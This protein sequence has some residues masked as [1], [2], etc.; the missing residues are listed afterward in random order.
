MAFKEQKPESNVVIGKSIKLSA[1]IRNRLQNTSK[2]QRI[3]ALV[4]GLLLLVFALV[5]LYL[6][7]ASRGQQTPTNEDV[8]SIIPNANGEHAKLLLISEALDKGD[9]KTAETEINNLETGSPSQNG[10]ILF[11]K[12]RL[13]LQTQQYEKAIQYVN[14]IDSE[15]L[16]E[17]LAIPVSQENIDTIRSVAEMALNKSDD[18]MSEPSLGGVSG[19]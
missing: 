3:I 18:S 1:K 8:V 16:P 9:T 17:E 6:Y 5:C 13:A 4:G 2:R 11:L 15:S 7:G 12:A 19:E 14:E 10:Q